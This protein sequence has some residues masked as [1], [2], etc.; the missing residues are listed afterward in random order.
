MLYVRLKYYF[1]SGYNTYDFWNI[2]C[3]LTFFYAV[4][5]V[6][7]IM[8]DW[9][10]SQLEISHATHNP[11]K[12]MEGLRGIAV[13][14]VF[15]V[16]Y[17][18]LITPWLADTTIIISSFIHNF[19]NLGV[20]LF[21]ILSGFLIYGTILSKDHF[22]S[23]NYIRRRVIRIYPTFLFVFVIYIFLS[24]LFPEE[25]KL[26]LDTFSIV[27]YLIQN[28]LFIPGLFD[29]KPLITVAWSLSYEVFY[30]ILIPI[31]IFSLSM[32]TWSSKIRV[33]FWVLVTFLGFLIA[34]L[35]GGPVR[36]LM[37]V[38]GIIL[39][40]LKNVLTINIKSW[41]NISFVLALLFVGF[42]GVVNIDYNVSLA[43]VYIL[44]F[45]FCFSALSNESSSSKWLVYSPLRWLG[46][47]SY[48]YYLIHGLTLKFLFL[49][50]PVLISPTQSSSFLYFWL[51][52]PFFFATLIV[53]FFLF[54]I[55][56][57]PFSISKRNNSA[58]KCD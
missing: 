9:I 34:F 36:L 37:F 24:V 41:G 25:S 47:M 27:I 3:F 30:Y 38:A 52:L 16:H 5:E 12:P 28:V 26:P 44:F 17:S 22:S 23:N 20:D 56:E 49:L 13:F 2:E 53:S 6:I 51:W 8:K 18:S 39:F 11:L 54:V 4:V 21:F 19:G 43:V 50:L 14:L 10:I 45:V 7:T 31:L 48:S 40:E 35:Y 1:D 58:L 15:L 33:T 55:I 57:R 42:G 29:V 46:N 32:K